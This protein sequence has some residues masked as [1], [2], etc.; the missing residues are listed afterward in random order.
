MPSRLTPAEVRGTAKAHQVQ[1][2]SEYVNSSTAVALRCMVKIRGAGLC[3]W[4]GSL[5]LRALRRDDWRCPDCAVRSPGPTKRQRLADAARLELVGYGFTPRGRLYP[6]VNEVWDA[7]CRHC[8][9]RQPVRLSQLRGKARRREFSPGCH[10]HRRRVEFTAADVKAPLRAI[11]MELVGPWVNTS[12]ITAFRC[13]LCWAPRTTSYGSLITT[14]GCKYCKTGHMRGMEA[15]A[16]ADLH[17]LRPLE[18]F[19]AAMTRW[20]VECRR[21]MRRTTVVP[22]QLRQSGACA[23]RRTGL[24]H[25]KPTLLY[26]M[27]NRVTGLYKIGVTGLTT[28]TP[29]RVTLARLGYVEV[30]SWLFPD[31]YAAIRSETQ[32]LNWLVSVGAQ[33]GRSHEFAG[34]TETFTGPSR[35]ALREAITRAVAAQGGQ[36]EPADARA[37]RHAATDQAI[38][39]VIRL[40]RG[41]SPEQVAADLG[42]R[43]V[44]VYKL[45]RVTRASTRS[46]RV[47]PLP[48]LVSRYQDGAT[49]S[50]L[51]DL[52]GVPQESV[53]R[54]LREAKVYEP[55]RD[56]GTSAHRREVAARWHAIVADAEALVNEFNSGTSINALAA[57]LG[58][59]PPIK[60]TR[61]LES[62]GRMD[63]AAS[64][65]N[66]LK[67]RRCDLAAMI[68]DREAGMT[69]KQIASRHKVSR[70]LV[71]K[72]LA[73]EGAREIGVRIDHERKRLARE[74]RAA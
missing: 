27:R 23:C 29:R 49:V 9:S 6:G 39:V 72:L 35:R 28:R 34:A 60:L 65:A 70:W 4:T 13:R 22:H 46:R 2:L 10:N 25:D 16:L 26:W 66:R 69:L 21:C 45:E 62:T 67:G 52:A 53:R 71:G 40:D 18:P 31:G 37:L 7:T 20:K 32:L 38:T 43:R 3:G 56:S 74:A 41:E 17:E 68:S 63:R 1:L 42:W 5:P 64:H 8:D 50:E 24:R 15:R 14:A 55:R 33:F 51:A 12:A 48:E 47:V 30:A 61:L 57:R 11:D 36:P 59:R 54:R 44:D 73:D 19:R 58:V